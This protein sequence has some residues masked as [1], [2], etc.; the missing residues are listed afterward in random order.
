MALAATRAWAGLP[1][2][3]TCNGVP[4]FACA[5]RT[6]PSPILLFKDGGYRAAGHFPN[7]FSIGQDM[8][9]RP[10]HAPIDHLE[11]DKPAL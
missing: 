2:M 1:R 5:V 7:D 9:V 3:S 6:Y 4:T 8:V 11:A 10:S